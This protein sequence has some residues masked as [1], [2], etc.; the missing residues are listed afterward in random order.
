[1]LESAHVSAGLS[2]L[3]GDLIA[4]GCEPAWRDP[5]PEPAVAEPRGATDGR[6]R[7]SADDQG[8][9]R[10]WCGKDQ[11]VLEREELACEAYRRA[12]GQAAQDL[13]AF[14][15]PTPTRLQGPRRRSRSRGGP[16]HRSRR[17]ASADPARAPLLSRAAVRQQ[18]GGATAAGR[19]RRTPAAWPGQRAARSRRSAHPSR[20]PP[21]SSRGHRRIRGR[22]P[23]RPHE[24]VS[25][26]CSRD[27]RS[28]GRS[29]GRAPRGRYPSR[30]PFCARPATSG[31]TI[32]GMP[33]HAASYTWSSS[34]P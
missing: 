21:R 31:R 14:V 3:T 26:A 22:Y 8:D 4:D 28:A 15:H 18:P 6:L 12:I 5:D 32:G 16:R 30:P 20:L 25:R 11:R 13:Q 7:P 24:P 33:F 2:R 10:G 29:A 17:R 19:A 23:R 1:M 34:S 9:R 27:C